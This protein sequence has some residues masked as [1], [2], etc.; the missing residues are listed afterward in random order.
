VIDGK[1]S[2]EATEDSKKTSFLAKLP[3]SPNLVTL[4]GVLFATLAA[5]L[6]ATSHLWPAVFVLTAAGI[7]DFFDGYLARVQDRQSKTGSY[8]DSV[9]DRVVEAVL[10]GGFILYFI[11]TKQANMAVLAFAVG[12]SGFLISYER[13]KGEAMGVQA[14]GGLMERAERLI[15]LGVALSFNGVIMIPLLWA[16]LVLNLLTAIARFYKV[17]SQL[18]TEADKSMI[19]SAAL[20]RTGFLERRRLAES[21]KGGKHSVFWSRFGEKSGESF[22]QSFRQ[23][24]KM[25]RGIRRESTRR[26]RVKLN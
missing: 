5:Y 13:A 22:W 17:W 6:T 2:S 18:A 19:K 14:K 16:L 20:K 1:R 26:R 3:I 10:I 8:L 9:V 11:N 12:A 24:Y 21:K 23:N 15:V 25:R 7:T 4:S